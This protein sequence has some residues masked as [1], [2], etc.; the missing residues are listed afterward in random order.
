VLYFPIT[1]V[2]KTTYVP[3][4]KVAKARAAVRRH[5]QVRDPK[6]A[7]GHTLAVARRN[8][9][10]TYSKLNNFIANLD[11]QNITPSA[12]IEAINSWIDKNQSSLQ[13]DE[14]LSKA[15][16]KLQ[17]TV[18]RLHKDEEQRQFHSVKHGGLSHSE[19]Q[20]LI[21]KYGRGGTWTPISRMNDWN[22]SQLQKKLNNYFK[23]TGLPQVYVTARG[24]SH[25]KP[26]SSTWFGAVGFTPDGKPI[27]GTASSPSGFLSKGAHDKA[28][29]EN[30]QTINALMNTQKGRQQLLDTNQ[31][32]LSVQDHIK[33]MTRDA[34]KSEK[35]HFVETG[36][37]QYSTPQELISSSHAAYSPD[38]G[39]LK[40]F[41]EDKKGFF[42][43]VGKGI[44][45]EAQRTGRGILKMSANDPFEFL[46][47][48]KQDQ[49][50]SLANKI[51]NWKT[52]DFEQSRKEAEAKHAKRLEFA[53]D[54]DVQAAALWLTPMGWISKV[55][56]TG[57]IVVVAAAGAGFGYGATQEGIGTTTGRYLF[58]SAEGSLKL[59]T[60]I[61]QTPRQFR[62]F[63]AHL[64]TYI[65]SSE[66]NK[67]DSYSFLPRD[68]VENPLAPF[69]LRPEFEKALSENKATLKD[70]SLTNQN[71]DTN[72]RTI[73]KSIKNDD[74]MLKGGRVLDIATNK[75]T[76]SHK[77]FDIASKN[78]DATLNKIK[79]LIDNPKVR[80]L[81][82]AEGYNVKGKLNGKN[83]EIDIAKTTEFDKQVFLTKEGF[84]IANPQRE[85]V[86]KLFIHQL[87]GFEKRKQK[88]LT[89]FNEYAKKLGFNP[90]AFL[91]RQHM[92]IHAGDS[93]RHM[94]GD[95]FTGKVMSPT[96]W[97]KKIKIDD[98][99]LTWLGQNEYIKH[100]GK[101]SKD[102]L[103]ATDAKR[104][105]W[106]IK[107]LPK[108]FQIK[109]K[110]KNKAVEQAKAYTA[111]MK[112]N[113]EGDI[114]PSHQT[115][116]GFDFK[117]RRSQ[118]TTEKEWVIYGTISDLK[119]RGWTRSPE[120]IHR[121]V[122]DIPLGK[123]GFI[124]SI[125]QIILEE[126]NIQKTLNKK[127]RDI[128]NIKK[129][130]SNLQKNK[131][132]VNKK[133]DI[134]SL[135]KQLKSKTKE[136]NNLKQNMKLMNAVKKKLRDGGRDVARKATR[137]TTRK[138]P[139]RTVRKTSDPVRRTSTY[140]DPKTDKPRI[141]EYRIPEHGTPRMPPPRT[142]PPRTTRYPPPTRSPPPTAR[143]PPKV[144]L[145]GGKKNGES[146][147]KLKFRLKDKKVVGFVPVVFDDKGNKQKGKIFKSQDDAM[148]EGMAIV[149]KSP[150]TEVKIET[151]T[152]T[153]AQLRA[154]RRRA[155]PNLFQKTKSGAKLK[156]KPKGKGSFNIMPYVFPQKK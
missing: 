120:G 4:T 91:V 94:K 81:A 52:Y 26:K 55:G 133:K 115:V 16:N 43:Q 14:V 72:T 33:N 110:N 101:G 53:T 112:K 88:D 155:R 145:T 63:L 62:D 40:D 3:N 152:T 29:Q 93:I 8:A 12:K 119:H 135:E 138:T 107:D 87:R 32:S 143:S 77:D 71:S 114:V 69:R 27:I 108:Q 38:Q 1:M 129:K 79:A 66:I 20:K 74:A 65:P 136:K 9:H 111:W 149:E 67:V 148:I 90:H 123:K 70:I 150:F 125:K 137:K 46:K 84:K 45:D 121:V 28:Q 60:K 13:H 25:S 21:N 139:R 39:K 92:A 10:E 95:T 100:F 75:K 58:P 7:S 85:L 83:I 61:V 24:I 80:R 98:E 130:K 142:P 64:Q 31:L 41:E 131:S 37:L 96:N 146:K 141:P 48:Y 151:V 140:R 127:M 124:P 89:K 42:T 109:H 117:G 44:K 51:V 19:A 118:S 134:K 36:K 73:L 47:P 15:K 156:E 2:K 102:I 49:D 154:T 76:P 6:G 147:G 22:R 126:R 106:N 116:T 113:A 103:V 99:S 97:E 56:T 11:T 68:V 86:E 153:P 122:S 17:S 35:K 128:E 59:G 50:K 144:K 105:V 132:T 78:P 104:K 18:D 23:A 82:T 57:K 34:T 54:S 5:A 30:Q